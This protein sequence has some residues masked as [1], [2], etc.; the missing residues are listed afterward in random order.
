VHKV[1]SGRKVFGGDVVFQYLE[2]RVTGSL[3]LEEVGLEVGRHHQTVRCD[4]LREPEGDRAAAGADLETTPARA[5]TKTGEAFVRAGVQG[6]LEPSEPDALLSPS[7]VVD[8]ALTHIGTSH[9]W[10]A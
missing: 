4:A 9:T 7:V 10:Q 3:H 5:D 8:V 2:T 6:G 1:E